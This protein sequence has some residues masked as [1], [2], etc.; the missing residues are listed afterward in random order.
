VD[1]DAVG[2]NNGTSWANSWTSFASINWAGMTNGDTLY[3]SGGTTSKTY[4]ERMTVGRSYVTIKPGQATPHNGQVIIQPAQGATPTISISSK[5]S[6][7]V[8]GSGGLGTYGIKIIGNVSPS[9]CCTGSIMV[10]NTA[11]GVILEYLEV[12]ATSMIDGGGIRYTQ[13]DQ[14]KMLGS[15]IRYN[16]IHDCDQDG[17]DLS[18][19]PLTKANGY[20][21]TLKIHHNI[22][23]R[24][25]DDHIESTM[26]GL[27]IYNN[28]FGNRVANPLRGHPD[29]HQF[30]NSYYRIYNNTYTGFTNATGGNS[31]IYWEPDGGENMDLNN[32]QP[33]CFKVYN[34]TFYENNTAS[35]SMTGIQLGLSDTRFTSISDLYIANN[36]FIGPVPSA[37]LVVGYGGT[38]LCKS[39]ITNMYV[40]NN[41]FDRSSG[42][43]AW[44]FAS[45]SCAGTPMNYGSW[46]SG[47]SWIIDYNI[48]TSS[49]SSEVND[50][51][52]GGFAAYNTWKAA[53]GAQEHGSTSSSLITSPTFLPQVGSPAIDRGVSLISLVGFNSD[54]AGT[55]R[56]MG[57]A[58]DIGAYE[59][60]GAV[61]PMKTPLYP[62]QIQVD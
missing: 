23:E 31:I 34:N 15:E 40:V 59:N 62:G 49:G 26:G 38:A 10:S 6:V 19:S 12:T 1:K 43:S 39:G 30:Y 51:L 4:T 11:R 20:G 27:D 29:G 50:A 52:H 56:P 21:S 53:T 35:S 9:I 36:D 22:I 18:I 24:V 55:T 44:S 32:N 14:S 58:W 8:S 57:N 7:I 60:T 25:N 5:D 46:G 2:S 33:C 3:I 45:P 54:K 48:Y 61:I 17:L 47:A 28:I 37:A 13:V 41:V 42:S 16:W